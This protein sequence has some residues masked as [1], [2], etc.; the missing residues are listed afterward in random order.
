MIPEKLAK[1]KHQECT[2]S[3]LY[4]T[5]SLATPHPTCA[6]SQARRSGSPAYF[7]CCTVQQHRLLKPFYFADGGQFAQNVA[8]NCPNIHTRI[9]SPR[10]LVT[11]LPATSGIAFQWTC[12]V[13]LQTTNWDIPPARTFNSWPLPIEMARISLS[14]IARGHLQPCLV[15]KPDVTIVMPGQHVLQHMRQVSPKYLSYHL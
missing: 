13:V 10:I 14:F 3:E 5:N 11:A 6:S 7:C 9:R 8:T 1:C 12:S 15:T 4:I 2:Y